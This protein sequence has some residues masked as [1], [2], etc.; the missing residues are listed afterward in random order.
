MG[1]FFIYWAI[2]EGGGVFTAAVDTDVLLSM[3]GL[4][5]FS[6]PAILM[7]LLSVLPVYP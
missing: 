4:I 1:L 7:F 6:L 5:I 2:F 3:N